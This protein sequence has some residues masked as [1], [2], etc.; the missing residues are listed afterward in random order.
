M[1]RCSCVVGS[2]DLV[3]DLTIASDDAV[4]RCNSVNAQVGV[5]GRKVVG[6]NVGWITVNGVLILDPTGHVKYATFDPAMQATSKP[7]TCNPFIFIFSCA[8]TNLS[9]GDICL[10]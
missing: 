7:R 4:Y 5:G 6:G 9:L 3:P 2:L 10:C 1:V 8:C